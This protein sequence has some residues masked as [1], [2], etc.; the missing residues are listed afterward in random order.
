[1]KILLP[2]SE[3]KAAAVAGEPV[4]LGDLSFAFLSDARERAIAGA[5]QND[6]TPV[7]VH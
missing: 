3:G 1:M 6:L 4:E 5:F 7:A 2:P